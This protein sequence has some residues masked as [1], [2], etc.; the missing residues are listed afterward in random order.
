MV[1]AKAAGQER[2]R[3]MDE[4][5]G[6]RRGGSGVGG[7]VDMEMGCVSEKESQRFKTEQSLTWADSTGAQPKSK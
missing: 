6:V 3:E 7:T 2:N 5:E 4:R 1:E